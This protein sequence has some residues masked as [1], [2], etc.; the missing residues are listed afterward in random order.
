M[1]LSTRDKRHRGQ[2][3]GPSDQHS[4]RLVMQLRASVHLKKKISQRSGSGALC[5]E[6][7]VQGLTPQRLLN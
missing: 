1:G 3:K 5:W 7:E 6:P 2:G 4:C